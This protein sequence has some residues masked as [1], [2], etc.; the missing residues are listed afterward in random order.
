L[1]SP[2]GHGKADGRAPDGRRGHRDEPLAAG[3]A[4]AAD[5]LAELEPFRF[6]ETLDEGERQECFRLRYRAVVEF[7]LAPAESL[8]DGMERDE[9]DHD[10]VQII[11]CDGARPIATCRLVLPA[12]GKEL[13]AAH[14][15]GFRLPGATSA[16][17]WGR[18][19]VDP[20]YRGDGHSIFMGLAAQG[21]RSMR[22]RGYS[23]CIAAT[24]KR[25][26]GLFE[27]LGFTVT[28]LGP[29]RRYWGDE[30]YPI[31]CAARPTIQQLETRRRA[32]EAET[33]PARESPGS[34]EPPAQ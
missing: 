22:A 5:I 2:E 29:A 9:F 8:S 30:R 4:I 16:V 6:R 31:L 12:P 17:E 3:D 33:A 27:A 20:D 26:I 11:G 28:V 25:L 13:P 32:G 10:A 19:V 23:T 21:W 7:R 24:P 1:A 18:V 15:F 34:R 14:A